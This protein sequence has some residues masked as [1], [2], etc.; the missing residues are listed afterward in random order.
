VAEAQAESSHAE[1][2]TTSKFLSVENSVKD[3]W[4]VEQLVGAIIQKQFE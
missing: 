2:E 3:S 4:I 1:T